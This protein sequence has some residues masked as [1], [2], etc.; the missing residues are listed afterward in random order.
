ML[1]LR[2]HKTCFAITAIKPLMSLDS[3]KMIYYSYVHSIPKYGII[4]WGNA[5]LAKVSLKFKKNYKSHVWSR[6]N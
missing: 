3:I 5:P 6:Q 4:F 1:S 2:L